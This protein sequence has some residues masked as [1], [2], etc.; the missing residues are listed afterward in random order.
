MH[1]HRRSF[2][3]P[4]VPWSLISSVSLCSYYHAAFMSGIGIKMSGR[5]GSI[6]L[7]LASSFIG[8]NTWFAVFLL[9]PL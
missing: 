3:F 8:C 1:F 9:L 5:A 2:A 6:I 4:S 7:L